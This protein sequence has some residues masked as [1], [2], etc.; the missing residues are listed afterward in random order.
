[1]TYVNEKRPQS[2]RSA[3]KTPPGFGVLRALAGALRAP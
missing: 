3:R 2:A 1:M